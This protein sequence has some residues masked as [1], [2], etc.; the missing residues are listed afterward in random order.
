MRYA[1]S[2]WFATLALAALGCTGGNEAVTPGPSPAGL[3]QGN[4][5]LAGLAVRGDLAETALA[6]FTLEVDPG[7]SSAAFHLKETRNSQATDDVY[8]LSIGN[9]IND[10]TVK[11]TEINVTGSTV[12]VSYRV[13]HPFK[14]PSNLDGP[15]TAANRAD[16]GISGRMVFLAD[17]DT[18]TG[19]TFFSDV[20]A[21]T[22]LPANADGFFQPKGLLGLTG[23]TANAFPFKSLV[24]LS[25]WSMRP[26]TPAPT[27]PPGPPSAMAGPYPGTTTRPTVGSARPSAPATTAGPG[28]APSTKARRP[29]TPSA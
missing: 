12:D 7:T 15:A 21:N 28:T 13:T 4:S 20:V 6:L 9:F 8:H 29:A 1:T 18:A 24:P 2:W 16:L 10:G 23:Y 25:P 11:V 19:N 3:P 27:P 14:G 26:W 5:A 22:A 17:V